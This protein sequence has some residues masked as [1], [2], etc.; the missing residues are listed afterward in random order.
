MTTAMAFVFYARS[1]SLKM[2]KHLDFVWS[3]S[4]TFIEEFL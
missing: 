3:I 2:I 4:P 1:M